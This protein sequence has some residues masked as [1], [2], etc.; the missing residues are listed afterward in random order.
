MVFLKKRVNYRHVYMASV[1]LPAQFTV[2]IN[3][4]PQTGHGV[5]DVKESVE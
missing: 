3:T 5:A 4:E 1:N 2:Y